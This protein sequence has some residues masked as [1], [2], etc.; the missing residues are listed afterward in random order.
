M[1]WILDGANME[2]Y[3]WTKN[4]KIAVIRMDI[5]AMILESVLWRF[6]LWTNCEAPKMAIMRWGIFENEEKEGY[7]SGYRLY[8]R[9]RWWDN[10]KEYTKQRWYE[11]YHVEY[12]RNCKITP[13]NIRKS[14]LNKIRKEKDSY[15]FTHSSV[16]WRRPDTAPLSIYYIGNVAFAR[17]AGEE[18]A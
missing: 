16:D 13:C 11:S 9:S 4:V 7:T 1:R 3:K 5:F 17:E 15:G 12:V 8:S 10:I 2:T 18:E 6:R 14:D